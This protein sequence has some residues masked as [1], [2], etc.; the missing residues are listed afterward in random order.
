MPHDPLTVF[1]RRCVLLLCSCLLL[2]AGNTT[3]HA[4]TR[5]NA[6]SATRARQ[7]A[8]EITRAAQKR[9]LDS[10]RSSRQHILDSARAARKIIT[11]SL[12][13]RRKY[14]ESKY[15]KDSVAE[16]RQERISSIR[17]AQQARMD[18]M[19]AAR[20]YVTDSIVASREAATAA[21][22]RVQ[23]RRT[24][25]L[26]AIKKYRTS[27]RFTDSVA[28]YRKNR[29]DS[30]RAVRQSFTDSI[31]AVRQAN[32]DS[33]KA[34]RKVISDSLAAVRKVRTD[35]LAGIRKQKEAAQAKSKENKVRD[36]K[37]KEKETEKKTNLAIEL[38]IK[39]KR[40]VYSNENMLKKKWSAPRRAVQNTFT[41]YNYY[42]N[43]NR[44]MEEAEDNMLRSAKDN[45]DERIALFSF[46]PLR[47]STQ[48]AADMDSVIQKVSLGIQ[49][50]DPRT[51]WG[52]DLYLLLGKAY[53]YKGDAENATAAFRYIIALRERAKAEAAKKNA[54]SNKAVSGKSKEAPSFVTPDEKKL[55][56]FLKREPANN[57]GLLWLARTY[58]AYGKL[59]ESES[60]LDLLA[61]D[62]KFPED[63]R[64]RLALEKA[65]LALKKRND[66]EATT[67]LAVVAA[68]KRISDD[69]RRRAAYLNGQLLQD[70]GD[71]NAAAKQYAF[72]SELHPKIDMDFYARRNRA[73]SLMQS[74]GVQKD[75]IAS[76]KSMLNDGKF[77]TYYEQIYYVLGRL[78][79]NSGDYKGA[80]SYLKE[81]I[82]APK[83]TKKQKAVSFA[84]LG[85]IYFNTAEYTN[86]KSAFDSA[87]R[88]ASYAPDDSSVSL[89][90]RR[91]MVVDKIAAPSRVIRQQDSLLALG[92]LSEREQRSVARRYIKVLEARMA[93]STF[94]AENAGI[95]AASQGNDGSNSDA[96]A[97]TWYFANPTLMQQGQA[98][99]RRKW[100]TRPAVDNWRRS[101]AIAASGNNAP[102]NNAGIPADD[103]AG[104][105]QPQESGLPTEDMLLAYIPTTAEARATAT[106]R[107]QR[108]FVD[109]S[110]AYVRQFED[111]T[112]ASATL[113][114]LDKRWA[115]NPYGAEATYLRYLIALRRNNLKEAQS[116]SAKL[117]AEYPGTQWADLVAP[118]SEAGNNAETTASVGSY[119]DAT[120]DLLQ[121][122]QYG[123]VLAR[124]RN[125][126]RQYTE[127][128]TY[129]N[130]FLIMEAMA[131]A[132]S[133]QYGEADTILSNFIKTHSGDP[134][135]PWAEQVLSYVTERK[136]IDTVKMA[137]S[138]PLPP[139]LIAPAANS[140]APAKT[141]A[142]L[143]A[144]PAPAEYAYRPQEAHYFVFAANKMEPRAM[145]VK[146]G[147]S[148]MNTFKFG[149][150]GLETMIEPMMAG[151]AIIA[152]KS[153]KNA[154][155]A[156]SYMAQ[157]RDAKMLLRE[158]EPNEYQTF[159]IS[160][161][162][163]RKLMAD[164]AV[165]SYL[166][167][168]RGH[169]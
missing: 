90:S 130:R 12:Q 167:F 128:E 48:F 88:Y 76:L 155:T 4:Q 2:F 134:L 56:N 19:K 109:M 151:K 120:Y 71:Y 125:A 5:F 64:G 44:K 39:K 110:T 75:A 160:A 17:E 97:M 31:A 168:Y 51:K 136:K 27:K 126:R 23:Q 9:T 113:D 50:H 100:G 157:F 78:S 138:T 135:A 70:A 115:S 163:F 89:A 94:R 38:K 164:K 29:L 112:R 141:P 83:T 6:D 87:T 129:S 159:V 158:Y 118:A 32:M 119:Y 7:Q 161:S 84:A 11:D 105:S 65:F 145:G 55:L 61:A 86:A 85:N 59:N 66:K 43:A 22:K 57:D 103:A 68:D 106:S 73:Y 153:F 74:G 131:Y 96:G 35:S 121:Q 108:A 60:V 62:S 58:T 72:V 81:G 34:V 140:G 162:N 93:D 28:I 82:A 98:E 127:N 92:T 102:G 123:E 54:Y 33:L 13:A 146:A 144:G 63:M 14:R 36:K 111:Y 166:V 114:T 41:H 149:S 37:I 152:V 142:E 79:A 15:F 147:I 18:S 30:I 148:D 99:F 20:E 124:T 156:K 132:G 91:A 10:A 150:A 165:G 77:S 3:T 137:P 25:S 67:Q 24:D 8:L 104:N 143:D 154:A 40:S 45:W 133:A 42:F 95:A 26:A 80:V 69:L 21:L 117:Q 107:L 49:I 46:D 16:V 53:F 169:Y 47:D 52:D 101:S 122:R 139:S 116:W 1:I